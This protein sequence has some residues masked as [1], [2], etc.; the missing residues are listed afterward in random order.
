MVELGIP[1]ISSCGILES[2]R[3]LPLREVACDS[4]WAEVTAIWQ[5]LEAHLGLM[6]VVAALLTASGVNS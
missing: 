5:V 6:M 1:A 3:R 2:L 4:A